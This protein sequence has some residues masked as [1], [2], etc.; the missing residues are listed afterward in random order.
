FDALLDSLDDDALALPT[1][2]GLSV[3]ELVAHVEAVDRAFVG[4][5][6]DPRYGFIGAAEVA[7]ITH[8]MLPQHAGESFAETVTRFRRTRRELVELADRLPQSQR[9]AGYG[10]DDSLVIRAFETWTHGDDIRRAVGRADAPPDAAVMRT[11]TE[12]AM[13]SLP[14]A[15]AARGTDRS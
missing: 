13:Q 4:E 6:D 10:R 2:N 12:L 8:E 14:L 15:M 5:A 7:A 11:M 9:L 1:E 3:H